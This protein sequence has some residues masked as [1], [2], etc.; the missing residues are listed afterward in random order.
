M[1]VLFRKCPWS[2]E[3]KCIHKFVK[4]CFQHSAVGKKIEKY[5]S[6]RI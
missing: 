3:L 1:I 5:P 2:M 4:L 6:N